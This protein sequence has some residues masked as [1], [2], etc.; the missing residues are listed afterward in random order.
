MWK[1]TNF[2]HIHTLHDY[3]L[4]IASKFVHWLE[5]YLGNK[6]ALRQ[7]QLFHFTTILGG[8]RAIILQFYSIPHHPQYHCL[9][10]AFFFLLFLVMCCVQA[11]L[12]CWQKKMSLHQLTEDRRGKLLIKVWNVLSLVNV[13][14]WVTWC[15]QFT[16][17][18][19]SVS[20]PW[21]AVESDNE[22][23]NTCIVCFAWLNPL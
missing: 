5:R 6:R 10:I 19:S 2:I 13:T 20:A 11:L 14:M 4:D 22:T 12:K 21:F 1:G 23:T 8:G 17:L 3:F 18:K 7:K 9:A 15:P 16:I